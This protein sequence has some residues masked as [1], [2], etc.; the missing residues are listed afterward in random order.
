MVE[1]LGYMIPT[2]APPPPKPD[3]KLNPLRHKSMQKL[4]KVIKSFG[5]SSLGKRGKDNTDGVEVFIN[6][7]SL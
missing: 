5:P 7:E 6:I 4:R 3:Q 1:Q 2:D